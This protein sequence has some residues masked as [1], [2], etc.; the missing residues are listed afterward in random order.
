M[1]KK[2]Q[3][4]PGDAPAFFSNIQGLRG[5]AALMV[6]F[7]HM[8]P[9]ETKYFGSHWIPGYF[10][11][12]G[13]AGVDLFFVISGFVMVQAAGH[14]FG[15]QG[16]AIRFFARRVVRIYPVYWVYSA[17]MLAILLAFPALVRSMDVAHVDVLA[18]FTLMPT[19]GERLLPQAWTLTYEVYFYVGFACL[20]RLCSVRAVPLAL[21]G[22]CFVILIARAIPGLSKGLWLGLLT[23]PIVL[24]FI[25]GAL[26]AFAVRTARVRFGWGLIVCGIAWFAIPSFFE[27]PLTES[28]VGEWRMV[29]FGAPSVLLVLGAALV[30]KHGDIRVPK[31][32][33]KIGDAS[34]T[35]Y[36]TH[37]VLA[38]IFARLI[39]HILVPG[40]LSLLATLLCAI[41][42]VCL[43]VVAYHLLENPLHRLSR[44]ML[45]KVQHSPSFLPTIQ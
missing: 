2:N 18:S 30:E 11:H 45:P 39:A 10:A 23:D 20:I 17:A 28:D 5:V 35:L 22:W 37:I 42:V 36:L 8:V 38:S 24:E 3:M 32:L 43:A 7:F 44:R 27:N 4:P 29:L 12:Y 9:I 26:A 40:H 41:G 34:Y 1:K 16:A 25:S 21:F 19:A 15:N 31:W 6:M 13:M 33:R 14:D